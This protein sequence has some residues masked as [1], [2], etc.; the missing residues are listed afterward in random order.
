MQNKLPKLFDKHKIC[1]ICEGKVFLFT[2]H[3]VRKTAL[4]LNMTLISI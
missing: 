4:T 3:L 1:V 2:S